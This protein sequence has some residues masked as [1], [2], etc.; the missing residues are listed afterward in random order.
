VIAKLLFLPVVGPMPCVRR[1]TRPR[2][3][4]RLKIAHGNVWCK[5]KHRSLNG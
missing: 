2:G 4:Y 1:P 3:M 5:F